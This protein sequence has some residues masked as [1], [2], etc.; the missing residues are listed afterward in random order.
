MYNQYLDFTNYY[1]GL[2]KRVKV[3]ILRESEEQIIGTNLDEF[4]K[5]FY[6]K[7][8]LSPIK[9]DQKRRSEKCG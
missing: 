8:S 5:Y 2:M 4:T 1:R 3:E 9:E 7:Y 6:D